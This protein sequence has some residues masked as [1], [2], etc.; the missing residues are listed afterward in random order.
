MKLEHI[1][2]QFIPID[3]IIHIY[4]FGNGLINDTYQIETHTN[5]FIMQRLNPAVFPQPEKLMNNLAILHRHIRA[6]PAASVKLKIPETIST[7]SQ[8]PYYIDEGSQCWRIIRY[9]EHSENLYRIENS[10][11]AQQVGFALGHFHQLISELPASLLHDTLPG[12]HITP[13]YLQHY[14]SII[15][16]RHCPPRPQDCVQWIENHQHNAH[17]LETAKQTGALKLRVIHGD[18][19]LDNIL[20]DSETGQAISLIDLDTLKPG[21]L[22]YDIGDCLRSCCNTAAC[23]TETAHFD[24]DICEGILKTYLSET[25]SFFTNNDYSYIYNAVLLLAFELGLRFFTDYL[26]GNIYFKASFPEQN[27]YRARHQFQLMADIEK[28][29]KTLQKLIRSLQKIYLRSL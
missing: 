26:E 18:P 25:H 23:E 5:R 8:Q 6:K 11:Q 7:R 20:F 14:Q 21:L 27:L 3:Q 4:P 9:I 1:A 17:S 2:D 22:H 19:K 24:M 16:S 13:Q 10:H 15:Q 28:Q 12:F 29:Q